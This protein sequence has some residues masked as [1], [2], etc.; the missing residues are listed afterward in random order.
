MLIYK[1]YNFNIFDFELAI[2]GG[3][4]SAAGDYIFGPMIKTAKERVLSVHRDKFKIVPAELG[5]RA[6]ILGAAALVS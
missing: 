1:L 6:G 4:I 3:G 5:N 2:I